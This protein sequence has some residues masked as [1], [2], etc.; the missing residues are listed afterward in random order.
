MGAD[1]RSSCRQRLP[2]SLQGEGLCV[3]FSTT[4]SCSVRC[5]NGGGRGAEEGGRKIGILAMGSFV[6]EF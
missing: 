2:T 5:G 4:I 1:R 6:V 3:R